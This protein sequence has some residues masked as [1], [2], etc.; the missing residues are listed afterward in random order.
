MKIL[1]RSMLAPCLMAGILSAVSFAQTKGATPAE[2]AAKISPSA[3]TAG[4]PSEDTVNSFMRQMVGY[5]PEVNWKVAQIRPSGVEGL[6]EVLVVITDSQGSN[7]NRFFVTADGQH[8]VTGEIIPFGAKPFEES[9]VKLEKG[10]T[11][12]AVGMLPA[13]VTIVEFSD[14]QCPHCK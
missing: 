7:T 6:T 5:N 10:V 14:M 9:R 4:V 1:M 8:A 11:G 12:P 2:P 3:T 13:P